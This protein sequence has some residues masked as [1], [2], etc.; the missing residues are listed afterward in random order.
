MTQEKQYS[1]LMQVFFTMLT[2]LS[3]LTKLTNFCLITSLI[4]IFIN[5][6]L[7]FHSAYSEIYSL[8]LS[9]LLLGLGGYCK[10]YTMIKK[11][12]MDCNL[13]EILKLNER[14]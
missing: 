12:E 5:I 6:I 7:H 13:K 14:L 3:T 4:L 1:F 10:L 11:Q 8:L 2:K 9:M